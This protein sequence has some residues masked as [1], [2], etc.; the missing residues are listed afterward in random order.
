MTPDAP[1][2]FADSGYWLG[3]LIPAAHDRDFLQAGFIA[4]LRDD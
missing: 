1:A 4:L 2:V 3:L